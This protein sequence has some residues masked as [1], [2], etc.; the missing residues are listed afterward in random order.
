MT[1]EALLL[2]G[3]MLA[4]AVVLSILIIYR[5]GR[6]P[7]A[8]SPLLEQRLLNIEGAIGRSDSAIREEF[9]RGRDETR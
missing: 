6:S 1:A 2:V 9:G 5:T 4:V 8:I 3:V 7:S